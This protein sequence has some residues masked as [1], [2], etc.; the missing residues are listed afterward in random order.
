MQKILAISLFFFLFSCKKEENNTVILPLNAVPQGFPVPSI[1]SDNEF[2][3]ARFQLGKRLFYDPILSRDS[4]ISCASCHNQQLGFTDGLAVSEGIEKRKGTR[5]AS[6]LFNLAYAPHYLR[7]GGVPTLEMQILVPIS[8]HAEMDFN[9]LEVAKKLNRDSNLVK[10]SWLCY[11]RKPDPYVIT[12]AIANFERTLLSGDSP[13]DK[14]TFQ[15]DDKALTTSELRGE[16]LFFSEKLACAKCHEGFNFTNYG[17][18]NNGLY[19]NYKDAGRFRLTENESDRALFKVPTLRNI[20]VTAPY[21]HD[22]S[23]K[24][25][26]EVIEHYNSGGKNHAHKNPLIKPLQLSNQE[27]QDLEFFLK[28]LTDKTFL[29]NKDFYK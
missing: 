7:E 13:Y 6:A 28:S 4:T 24:T 5:N 22:G 8:E 3:E 29:E 23:L 19:E 2:S 1:P 11:N 26:T 14:Y 12:R 21:M 18:E 17:F 25:L 27:K 15:K 10:Q 16:N 9:I 20:A